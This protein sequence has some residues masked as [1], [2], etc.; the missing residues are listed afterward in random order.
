[1]VLKQWLIDHY[2]AQP[3][4]NWNSYLCTSVRP[5]LWL[6]RG[7]NS[8]K[9][10][11]SGKFFRPSSSIK[12]WTYHFPIVN[13]KFYLI[14]NWTSSFT[15]FLTWDFKILLEILFFNLT[16]NMSSIYFTWEKSWTWKKIIWL[17]KFKFHLRF[18]DSTWDFKIL[19]EMNQNYLDIK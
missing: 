14:S 12:T 17:E 11:F 16:W 10:R 1:M 5:N 6:P 3:C 19:L 13:F 9:P 2:W 8:K 15:K 18:Q 4:S 7:Y